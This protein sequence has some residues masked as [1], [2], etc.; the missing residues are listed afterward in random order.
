MPFPVHSSPRVLLEFL[1]TVEVYQHVDTNEACGFLACH[2]H[3][4]GAVHV[5]FAFLDGILQST[6]TL[7]YAHSRQR[8]RHG[9]HHPAPRPSP[10]GPSSPT[11][12]CRPSP[13]GAPPCRSRRQSPRC[14]LP[15]ARATPP[16]NP[17]LRGLYGRGDRGS[18]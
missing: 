15:T 13:R 1:K 14:A 18:N 6:F 10:T 16:L 7:L 8:V 3:I 4:I 11:P 5:L 9:V 2:R 12:S 17:P